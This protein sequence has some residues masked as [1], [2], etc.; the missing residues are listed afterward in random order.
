MRDRLRKTMAARGASA[1]LRGLLVVGLVMAGAETFAARAD[2]PHPGGS[3]GSQ[4]QAAGVYRPDIASKLPAPRYAGLATGDAPAPARAGLRD[5]LSAAVQAALAY[6]TFWID[7]AYRAAGYEP[8]DGANASVAVLADRTAREARAVVEAL[9][10][11]E[12]D[13]SEAVERA[14]AAAA[15]AARQET[16]RRSA[17][18]R[19]AAEAERRRAEAR[20]EELRKIKEDLDR[21]IEEG[22]KKLENLERLDATK[23]TETTRRALVADVARGASD[24]LEVLGHRVKQFQVQVVGVAHDFQVV[25]KHLHRGNGRTVRK[26]PRGCVQNRDAEIHGVQIGLA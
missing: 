18:E 5:R 12:M 10:K 26:R 4:E 22:L 1:L 3:T 20:K 11:A 6:I 17:A 16:E 23:K 9:K 15:E 2:A 21:R 13:W 19:D 14:N 25:R 24:A 8:S 7:E